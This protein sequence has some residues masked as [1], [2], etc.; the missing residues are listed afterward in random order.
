MVGVGDQDADI[1]WLALQ[2]LPATRPVCDR[3]LKTVGSS[4]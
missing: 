3:V 4:A 2:I 1:F